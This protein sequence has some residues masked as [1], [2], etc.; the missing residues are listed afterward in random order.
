MTHTVMEF[1]RLGSTNDL[2]KEWHGAFGHLTFVRTDE[3]TQ[4]RGQ[5]DRHWESKA[6]Q[7]ILCSIL[8]KDVAVDRIR[9]VRSWIFETLMTCLNKWHVNTTFK[10][11][12]DLLVGDDKIAGI[13]IETKTSGERFDY[14]VTGIGLNVNQLTFKIDKATSMKKV[15][16]HDIDLKRIFN[17][18]VQAMLAAYPAY[19]IT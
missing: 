16:G 9:H 10:A 19:Q 2:L 5:F 17:E 1:G 4:G 13:L 12:N 18:L 15:T 7:N 14:V 3:Q 8:L 11:P 6:G